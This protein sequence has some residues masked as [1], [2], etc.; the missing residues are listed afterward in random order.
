VTSLLFDR[1]DGRDLEAFELRCETSD[2]REKIGGFT[3]ETAEFE[4]SNRGRDVLEDVELLDCDGDVLIDSSFIGGMESKGFQIRA[5]GENADEVVDI[6]PHLPLDDH[7]LLPYD[8]EGFEAAK[9]GRTF[10]DE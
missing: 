8:E 4:G 7:Q 3:E 5:L 6:R 10:H 2:G 1:V 9:E